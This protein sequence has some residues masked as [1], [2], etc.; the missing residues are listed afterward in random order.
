MSSGATTPLF[1]GS[2]ATADEERFVQQ[3]QELKRSGSSVLVTG[4]VQA[5]VAMRHGRLALG[6]ETNAQVVASAHSTPGALLPEGVSALDPT[7]TMI[8]RTNQHRSV[9]FED[10]SSAANEAEL[11]ELREDIGDAVAAFN[12]QYELGPSALR[13][14]VDSL[15]ELLDESDVE[16]AEHFLRDV[17]RSVKLVN[18]GCYFYLRRADDSDVVQRLSSVVDARVELRQTR[19]EAQQRWHI[20]GEGITTDWISL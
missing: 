1:R 7:V 17:S 12:A 2:G 11:S 16:D 18:G 20:P 4:K 6:D 14:T 8:R 13:A 9:T 3:L 15:G 10:A 5:N 19:R